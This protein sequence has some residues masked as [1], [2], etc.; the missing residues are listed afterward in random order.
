MYYNNIHCR[1]KYI[2]NKR[3]FVIQRAESKEEALKEKLKTGTE[4]YYGGH[5]R[6]ANDNNPM[7]TCAVDSDRFTV[8]KINGK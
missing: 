1:L 7:L 3:A 6:I 2:E 5:G 4:Y 8:N